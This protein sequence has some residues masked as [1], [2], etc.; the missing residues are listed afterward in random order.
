M[1]RGKLA[2]RVPLR[3]G[4][5]ASLC[6]IERAELQWGRAG[7]LPSPATT[8]ALARC[9]HCGDSEIAPA[10]VC[11]RCGQRAGAQRSTSA[12]GVLVEKRDVLSIALRRVI[13]TLL[14]GIV[15]GTWYAALEYARMQRPQVTADEKS[16]EC[17][18]IE[19]MG[20]EYD[21][22]LSDCRH[23]VAFMRLEE[24]ERK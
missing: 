3:Q 19:E 14:W 6:G 13:I 18:M 9:A 23:R 22:E 8:M 15:L 17:D 21:G 12:S 1:I 10:S 2:D 5:P 7:P 20:E 24:R 11:A 16:L 4:N